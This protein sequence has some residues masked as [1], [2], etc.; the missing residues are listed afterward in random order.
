[1]RIKE[2]SRISDERIVFLWSTNTGFH[3]LQG[4]EGKEF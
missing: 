3:I 4:D 2:I 1:M